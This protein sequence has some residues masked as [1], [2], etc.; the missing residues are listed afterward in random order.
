MRETGQ[1]FRHHHWLGSVESQ[2]FW[3][4]LQMS[5]DKLI[6]K[7]LFEINIRKKA[8]QKKKLDERRKSCEMRC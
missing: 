1:G 5:E 4:V 3:W 8:L 7:L 6:G 2:P